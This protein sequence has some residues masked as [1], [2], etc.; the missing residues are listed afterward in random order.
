MN[1]NSVLHVNSA[2]ERESCLEAVA[3]I[4][5]RVQSETKLTL[6]EIADKIDVSIGTISAA[7]NKKTP[8]NPM[9]LTRIGK[10]F[11][12]HLLDPF[13]ALSGARMVPLAPKDHRDVLVALTLVSA[14]I[15][16]ARDGEQG[17]APR[18][19]FS[20]VRRAEDVV[21]LD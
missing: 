20:M 19:G 15:A 3:E 4:L 10:H 13:A 21:T 1:A 17:R 2:V 12:A 11:G 6:Y 7:A 18:I 9:Y 8:L 5:R 14:K 16:A